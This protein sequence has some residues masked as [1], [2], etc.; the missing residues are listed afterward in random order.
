MLSVWGREAANSNP[1]SGAV[2]I[3]DDLHDEKGKEGG[4]QGRGLSVS[5]RSKGGREIR[6]HPQEKKKRGDLCVF[7]WGG[8]RG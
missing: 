1:A 2:S 3:Y 7:S 6:E 8:G 5:V 4:H